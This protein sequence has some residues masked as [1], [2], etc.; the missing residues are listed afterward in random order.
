MKSVPD[1]PKGTN[2]IRG[3]LAS[4][5]YKTKEENSKKLVGMIYLVLWKLDAPTAV[6]ARLERLD[7]ANEDG[8]LAETDAPFFSCAQSKKCIDSCTPACGFPFRRGSPVEMGVG[9][10]IPFFRPA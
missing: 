3:L 4:K 6:S 1:R 8:A 9:L 10:G 5:G 2:C 7:A